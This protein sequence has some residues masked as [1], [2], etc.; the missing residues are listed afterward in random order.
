MASSCARGRF[1]LD[2]RKHFLEK[3]VMQWHRLPR[4][5]YQERVDVALRDELSGY[6]GGGLGVGLGHLRDLFQQK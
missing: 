2:I 6:G 1:R 4:E 5:V 3:V